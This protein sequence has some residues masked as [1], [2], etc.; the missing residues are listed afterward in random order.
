VF[1]LLHLLPAL[2]ARY[3][4]YGARFGAKSAIVVSLLIDFAALVI[5]RSDISI[6]NLNF[7]NVNFLK[8]VYLYVA[9]APLLMTFFTLRINRLCFSGSCVIIFF[10][11]TLCWGFF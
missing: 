9:L 8:N 6:L 4:A 3:V 7:P 11:G 5:V 10:L 1:Y 2:A